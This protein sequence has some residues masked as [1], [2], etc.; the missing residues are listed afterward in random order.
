[1][2][3][4]VRGAIPVLFILTV[5]GC[6][7]YEFKDPTGASS[8]IIYKAPPATKA[9]EQKKDLDESDNT[10]VVK[11][12]SIDG[13]TTARDRV[14]IQVT[15]KAPAGIR[16]VEITINQRPVP[17]S[18]TQSTRGIQLSKIPANESELIFE[19]T[20][21]LRTGPNVIGVLATNRNFRKKRESITVV[22]KTA[23]VKIDGTSL[24]QGTIRAVVIGI[25]KYQNQTL[26]L[27]YADRDAQSFYNFLTN[28]NW[29]GLSRDRVEFIANE[30]A[31][32]AEIIK[33]VNATFRRADHDD[34]VILYMACHG[35]PD[36]S[37]EEVFFLGHDT[38]LNNIVGTAVRQAEIEW[39]MKGSRAG[40]ILL[41][42]DACHS[43]GI[44]YGLGKRS[45]PEATNR[46]IRRITKAK[47]GVAVLSAST[48]S[49]F[50]RE[51]ERW[52]GGHGVFTYYLII[53][54]KGAADRNNDGYVTI[55]EIYDYIYHKVGEDTEGNQYPELKGLFDDNL[56]LS[57]IR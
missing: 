28:V 9:D 27:K 14:D 40:K 12:H 31:T 26:N 54:L 34:L 44:G 3:M 35:S 33:R 4:K 19:K 11:V 18:E 38:D 52:G 36:E 37:G 46:L 39:A 20:V 43:G 48:A 49:Q 25:S 15:I 45:I 53:G 2:K 7:T 50:S 23:K 29:L 22:R 51:D 55:R 57:V 17:L 24:R 1:M 32:R 6:S 16:D 47:D 10:I 5:A 8:K 21:P 41:I 56:P 30:K 42:A 13:E